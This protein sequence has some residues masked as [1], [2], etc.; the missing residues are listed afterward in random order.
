M[1]G[2]VDEVDAEIDGGGI[3]RAATES[4][5]SFQRLLA[6]F[7]GEL[8]GGGHDAAVRFA[9]AA[10]NDVADA[11]A[12]P[13]VFSE[14]IAPFDDEVRPEAIHRHGFALVFQDAVVESGERGFADHEERTGVGKSQLVT[15]LGCGLQ[16]LAGKFLADAYEVAREPEEDAEPGG[17]GV[18]AVFG[19]QAFVFPNGHGAQRRGGIGRCGN[20]N[21]ARAVGGESECARGELRCDQR[22]AGHGALGEEFSGGIDDE[23]S[24][25]ANK[26]Q[27]VELGRCYR[28]AAQGFHGV[29]KKAGDV[30]H[31]G[32]KAEKLKNGKAEMRRTGK[33]FG[34]GFLGLGAEN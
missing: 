15:G 6:S 10:E 31:G 24:P 23:K 19:W 25:V 26:T 4:G 16:V 27:G 33:G 20:R 5:E 14:S 13:R 30:R 1:L 8:V 34:S 17:G 22:Q 32:K 11:K 7:A 29:D 18:A 9:G 2:F 28:A 3:G 12:R 21:V